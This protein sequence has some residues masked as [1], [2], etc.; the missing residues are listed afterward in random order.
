MKKN[1][2][3]I[4]ALT[5]SA[6][7]MAGL[8]GCSTSGTPQTTAQTASSGQ[9]GTAE[10]TET[11][12]QA[13]ESKSTDKINITMAVWSSSSAALQEEA[14]N[15]F[16]ETQDRIHFTVEMQS[17]DYAQYLGAKTVANDLPDLFYMNPYSEL[18]Q[19]AKNGYILDL[20]DQPFVSRIYDS[21]KAGVSYDGK[22]YGYP[23]SVE[24]WGIFYNIDL[25]EQAGITEIPTT[26][27]ELETIC[28][29]L[30][31]NDIT[32][33][34]AMYKDSWTCE[35]VFSALFAAAMQDNLTEWIQQMNQ[36]ESTF[37]QEPV[38]KVF[39]FLD[40]MKENSGINYMDADSTAGYNSFAS[41][42]AAM[43]FLGNFALRSARNTNP[44]IRI[45][46]MAIPISEDPDEAKIMTNTGVGIVVNP[47]GEHIEEALEVLDFL[48]DN[49]EGAKNW[50]S[51]LLDSVGG[52]LPSMPITLKNIVNEPFYQSATQY[53][54][55]GKT[56]DKISNQL[57][58]GAMEVIKSTVQGYFAGM[59]TQDEVLAQ[60][61]DEILKLAE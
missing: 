22:I 10:K 60:L 23:S 5:A 12:T 26:F 27:S 58:S 31:D 7:I 51:I 42:D 50:T 33:F 25:F 6:V 41:G 44:D 15:A 13:E 24:Y 43:I 9:S 61:D 56:M 38:D 18:Q 48:S 32:P 46:L 49:T 45:G 47:N 3:W 29:T 4:A 1:K 19:Y 54:A 35:Q 39:R 36:G 11:A 40:L 2:T 57:N 17:G 28:Q 8:S 37:R 30:K 34:A 55:E 16:N 53:V 14:A 59:S 21:T 20:S 52:A